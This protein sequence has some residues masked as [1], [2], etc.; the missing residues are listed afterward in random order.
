MTNNDYSEISEMSFEQALAELEAIVRRLE[1]GQGEL[2]GAIK[3]YERG[4]ALKK[5]CQAKLQEARTRVEKIV[6]G[7]DGEA[8]SVETVSGPEKVE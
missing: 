4:A 6:V 3:S 5:H 8:D 1:E 2:D 7:N